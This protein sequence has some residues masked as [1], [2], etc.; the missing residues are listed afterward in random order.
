MNLLE[1]EKIDVIA[2]FVN[3]TISPKVLRWHNKKYYIKQI[4]LTYEE[5]IG[6]NSVYCFAISDTNDNVF[7]LAYYPQTSRWTIRDIQYN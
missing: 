6:K 1:P 5:K 3:G 7:D 2:S 4:N